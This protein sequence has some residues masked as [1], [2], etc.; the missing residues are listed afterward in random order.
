MTGRV[1]LLNKACP[2]TFT[3]CDNWPDYKG[4]WFLHGFVTTKKLAMD[5]FSKKGHWKSTII[6]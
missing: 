1:Q 3:E 2:T 5:T 4:H 6:K